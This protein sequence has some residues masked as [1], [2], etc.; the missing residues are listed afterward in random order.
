MPVGRKA[1]WRQS[2]MN[3]SPL[4]RQSP[5]RASPQAASEYQAAS[6]EDEDAPLRFQ[7]ESSTSTARPAGTQLCTMCAPA[8]SSAT[9]TCGPHRTPVSECQRPGGAY[10]LHAFC[11]KPV[12]VC[13]GTWQQ[14]RGCRAA[15]TSVTV[16]PACCAGSAN[17]GL[18]HRGQWLHAG[19]HTVTAVVGV[20]ACQPP[21]L[22]TPC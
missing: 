9:G 13:A 5:N 17:A 20:R 11:C 22:L 21:M 2:K 6:P 16:T 19:G 7:L 18:A 10:H 15:G 3:K 4:R 8:Y 12:P 1:S 14:P